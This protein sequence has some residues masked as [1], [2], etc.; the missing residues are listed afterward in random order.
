MTDCSRALDCP[1]GLYTFGP[2]EG[3]ETFYSDGA[4]GL[5]PDSPSLASS[6]RGMDFMVRHMHQAVGLD[7][8]TAIRMASLTPAAILGREREIGSLEAGKRADLVELDEALTVRRVFVAGE[9]VAA[10]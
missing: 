2:L 7:L 3:G 6:V 8:P 9:Q 10:V 4:V 5:L 1:P